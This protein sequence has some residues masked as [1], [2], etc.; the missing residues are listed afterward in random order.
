MIDLQARAI[1]MGRMQTSYQIR[2]AAMGEEEEKLRRA[3]ENFEKFLRDRSF[4]RD[5]SFGM[6]AVYNRE[7]A[8]DDYKLKILKSKAWKK[9]HRFV[10]G[11]SQGEVN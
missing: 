8:I 3:D 10:K 2:A 9:K 11:F 5:S 1:W 4:S 6:A 7:N